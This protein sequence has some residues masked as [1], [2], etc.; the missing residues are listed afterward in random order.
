M[1]KKVF[2]L[3]A[4]LLVA[5][6][7]IIYLQPTDYRVARTAVLAAPREKLFEYVNDQRKFN[8]WNP[9]L[10]LDPNSKL[11]YKGPAAGVGSVSSW[12][13]DRNVGAGVSTIT[14][15]K[16][17]EL[18]RF[19]MQWLEPMTGTS[20]VDF[21]FKP[22]ADK[23]AVTWEMYG[24]N[25]FLGKAISLVFDCESMCGPQFEKGLA[26]LNATASAA[27]KAP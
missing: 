17:N 4:L 12:K 27:T 3:L 13:G 18:V 9:W 15:S 22:E 11:D 23:T 6:L 2:L 16:P 8:E 26:A 5:L 24:Q 1:L 21:T 14:E 19:H 25:D 7:T 10:K 20:T